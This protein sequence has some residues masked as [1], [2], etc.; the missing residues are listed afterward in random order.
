[1]LTISELRS[2]DY[3]AMQNLMQQVFAET[4][5]L[6]LLP[7]DIAF[8][9]EEFAQRLARR[10]QNG[11]VCM[12]ARYNGKLVGYAMAIRADDQRH[13]H[14][15]TLVIAVLADYWGQGIGHSLLQDLEAWCLENHVS[16]IEMAARSD[17]SRALALYEKFGFVQEGIKKQSFAVAGDYFDECIL[18]KL[19]L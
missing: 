6:L 9:S 19:L 11:S 18:A 3:V 5:N 12:L 14:V 7:E 13:R 8:S 1:M 15:A 10:L 2:G 4:D 16:R 17:N